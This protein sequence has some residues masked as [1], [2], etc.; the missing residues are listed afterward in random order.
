[1]GLSGK[2]PAKML[3][4]TDGGCVGHRLP[5]WG[6]QCGLAEWPVPKKSVLGSEERLCGVYA[7]VKGVTA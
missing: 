4:L 3:V 2:T 6:G 7:G 5:E 1:M